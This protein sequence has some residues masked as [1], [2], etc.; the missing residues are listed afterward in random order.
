MIAIYC[1]DR[2]VNVI[3][4]KLPLNSMS[5]PMAVAS[6]SMTMLLTR[7][8]AY[9]RLIA[10]SSN[11]MMIYKPSDSS[12]TAFPLIVHDSGNVTVAEW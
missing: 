3:L 5:Q 9:T 11:S 2:A 4:N 6:N 1:N 8:A 7:K 10:A 12:T